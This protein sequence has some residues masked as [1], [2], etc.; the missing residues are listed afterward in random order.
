MFRGENE[1]QSR[2]LVWRSSQK[3]GK[4]SFSSGKFLLSEALNGLAFAVLKRFVA[5]KGLLKDR[6]RQAKRPRTPK[7]H[8]RF[9]DFHRPL[10][11]I[12]DPKRCKNHLKKPEPSEKNA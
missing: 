2:F 1:R 11:I 9:S 4:S 3:K 6:S 10:S 7:K 5:L 8:G 12:P